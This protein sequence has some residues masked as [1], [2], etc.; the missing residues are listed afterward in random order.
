MSEN[1]IDS[2]APKL[3]FAL[4]VLISIP[5]LGGLEVGKF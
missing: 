4:E 2:S 3:Q 1:E 5:G